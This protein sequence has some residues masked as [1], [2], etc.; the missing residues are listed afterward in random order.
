MSQPFTPASLGGIFP[1]LVTPLTRDG[2]NKDGAGGLDLDVEGLAR[3]LDHTIA[4]GVTGVFALGTTGETASL[5]C[6]LRQA[7]VEETCRLV[8]SRVPV[9]I[10]ITDT[11]LAQS[12]ELAA[13]AHEAGAACVVAAPPYYYAISQDELVD[14]YEQLLARLPLPL[15]LYNIPSCTKI[16]LEIDTVRRLADHPQVLGIKDSSRDWDFFRSL[17]KAFAGRDDFSLLVG[18]EILLARAVQA[19]A[20]G[21]ICGGANMYP[22]LYV[23]LRQAAADGDPQRVAELHAVVE[24]ISETIYSVGQGNARLIQGIK[25]ALCGLGI[26]GDTMAPPLSS[27][28]E[29]GRAQVAGFLSNLGITAEST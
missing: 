15:L 13:V 29:E 10:G 17:A 7:M 21:G 12:L 27:L 28:S 25:A 4:G 5:P 16:A 2:S 19:G 11:C 1:P 14:Y 22:S 23:E 6:R 8:D 9:L 26:C 24:R 20:V 18:P 3:L